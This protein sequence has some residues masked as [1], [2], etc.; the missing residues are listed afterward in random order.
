MQETTVA[1]ATVSVL[2]VNWNARDALVACLASLHANPPSSPWEA[3]VVDNASVD[4]SV[5]AVARTAPWARVVA[6]A[7]NRGLAAANNQA[8][9]AA[10]GDVFV[11]SN[12]DVEYR[13]GALDALVDLLRRRP[14]A[15]FAFARLVHPDGEL[16]TSAGELPSLREALLGRGV[17]RRRREEAGGGGFWWDGWDA[18]D[19]RMV[20]HAGEAT[21]AVRR[22]MVAEIG[23]QDERFVLDWE[24]IDWTARGWAQDWEAWFC[25]AAEVVHL[26]GASI[27]QVPARW[28]VRSHRGMYRYFAKRRPVPA[29]PVLAGAFGARAALKLVA[30]LARRPMYDRVHRARP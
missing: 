16:Q 25:P 23:M 6:N 15:G 5:E 18:R 30:V 12:P 17:Q 7:T 24:G 26:G 4:G 22:A 13:A 19:E 20:G 1:R 14:R 2:I 3:I 11:V 28:V 29:R 10:R 8:M 21:Y 27:R 9:L